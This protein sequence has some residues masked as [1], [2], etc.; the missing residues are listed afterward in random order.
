MTKAV[1]GKPCAFWGRDLPRGGQ[2]P[3]EAQAKLTFGLQR[4]KPSSHGY[5][6]ATLCAHS[7]RESPWATLAVT[8][9]M[10]QGESRTGSL[11]NKGRAPWQCPTGA[12]TCI[13]PRGHFRDQA[14]QPCK[15]GLLTLSLCTSYIF[16]SFVT[17]PFF[18]MGYAPWDG[19]PVV[20]VAQGGNLRLT[21]VYARYRNSPALLRQT[22]EKLQGLFT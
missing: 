1:L 9:G 20:R 3:L 8:I 16:L 12:C 14:K 15:L 13:R 18:L 2:R 4:A 21:C 10:G 11:E 17:M 5:C 22:G 6:T 19:T 7:R